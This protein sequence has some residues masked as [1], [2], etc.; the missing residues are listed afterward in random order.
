MRTPRL[1]ATLRSLLLAAALPLAA[2]SGESAQKV[3][4]V[5]QAPACP[6]PAPAVVGATPPALA[7]PAA[8]VTPVPEQQVDFTSQMKE[9]RKLAR[10]KKIEE[11]IVAYEQ[12][13]ALDERAA[14]PHVELAR[15]HLD[16]REWQAARRHAEKAVELAPDSSSAWN[17]LGRARLALGEQDAA[18]AAFEKAIEKNRR[19]AYAWNNLGLVLLQSGKTEQAVTA[20]ETA[21]TIGA[22]EPYMWTNLGLAY[23]RLDRLVEAR[24]AYERAADQG[25]KI[26]RDALARLDRKTEGSQ[27][28]ALPDGG[29]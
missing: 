15:L 18:I 20:L 21:T 22:P 6:E 28:K 11:A 19:N 25:S 2:C 26:A 24:A 29:E 17:T 23:E 13:V 12:A 16:R 4:D 8:P 27:A 10:A 7:P 3:S 1:R 9:A 14:E 5:P